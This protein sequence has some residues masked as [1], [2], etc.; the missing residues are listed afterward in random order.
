MCFINL[1]DCFLLNLY[2]LCRFLNLSLLRSYGEA[3]SRCRCG[4]RGSSVLGS[5]AA[6]LGPSPQEPVRAVH[7]GVSVDAQ[8]NPGRSLLVVPVG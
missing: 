2:N 4:V 5:P 7:D 8:G 3:G 6:C 1:L